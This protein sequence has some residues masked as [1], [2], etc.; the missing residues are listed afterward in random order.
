MTSTMDGFLRDNHEAILV[1]V[2]ARMRGDEAMGRVAA[3][4]ELSADDLASQVLGFWLQGIR[5]DLTLGSTATM[6]QSLSWL[7]RLRTGHQLQF[8]DADVL[9]LFDFISDEID[10]RLESADL[11][12]A[13]AAYHRRVGRLITDVFP[14]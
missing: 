4:R 12:E 8:D 10:A 11:R 14:G 13:Y 9:Q 5:S 3:Q 2:Q 1:A 7:A 6:E